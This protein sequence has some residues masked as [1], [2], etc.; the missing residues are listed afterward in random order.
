MVVTA[1]YI[2]CKN[3]EFLGANV[4]RVCV[5][6]FHVYVGQKSNVESLVVMFS[7]FGFFIFSELV[8]YL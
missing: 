4:M 2:D 7:T 8:V 1:V 6:H 3:F 5:V